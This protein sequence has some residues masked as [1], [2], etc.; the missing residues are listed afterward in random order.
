MKKE[1][2]YDNYSILDIPFSIEENEEK[3]P[4]D[5]KYDF[6][7]FTNKPELWNNLKKELERQI[8]GDKKAQKYLIDL[9]KKDSN[10]KN[11]SSINFENN[12]EWSSFTFSNEGFAKMI[13][14]R[15][16]LNE[17]FERKYEFTIKGLKRKSKEF[18]ETLIKFLSDISYNIGR[19]ENSIHATELALI[20]LRG[21]GINKEFGHI[22]EVSFLKGI[23]LQYL[24]YYGEYMSIKIDNKITDKEKFILRE[25]F[26][27]HSITW[28][29]AFYIQYER[30]KNNNHFLNL[31]HKQNGHLIDWLNDCYEKYYDS[32]KKWRKNLP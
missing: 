27:K 26:K 14:R 8:N 30:H 2:S 17:Y 29:T 5:K 11:F 4:E 1:I 25:V 13:F 6:V 21:E 19:L 10:L 9:I 23:K 15:N 28:Q 12:I 3:L 24:P 16:F 7:L 18:K 20:V 22:T 32:Y 31:F